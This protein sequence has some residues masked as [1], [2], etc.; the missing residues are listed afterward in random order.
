MERI[1]IISLAFLLVFW[2]SLLIF[3]FITYPE[4]QRVPLKFVSGQKASPQ[5]AVIAAPVPTVI[6]WPAVHKPKLPSQTPRNLFAAL[7]GRQKRGQAPHLKHASP[8]PP[9]SG[10]AVYTPAPAPPPP[11]AEEIAAE[12]ARRQREMA[13]QQTRQQMTQYRFVG[14]LT[15]NGEAQ[16]FVGRGQEIFIVRRGEVLEGQVVVGAIDETSITLAVP[17]LSVT[18]KLELVSH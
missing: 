9:V 2:G 6:R 5:A 10:Q 14:Y 12:Q 4:P 16:A 8:P 13:I 1:K 7:P 17:P 15:T 3:R 18:S 11:S